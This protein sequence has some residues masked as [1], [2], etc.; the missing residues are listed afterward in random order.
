MKAHARITIEEIVAARK[1]ISDSVVRTPL[2]RPTK[3]SQANTRV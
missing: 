1:R 2:I 3:A